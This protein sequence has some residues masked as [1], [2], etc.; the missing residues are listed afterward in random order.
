MYWWKV[1][2]ANVCLFFFLIGPIRI[3]FALF[4]TEWLVIIDIAIDIIFVINMVLQF[5]QSFLNKQ[6]KLEMEFHA[7]SKKYL[8]GFFLFD[9]LSLV[10]YYAAY[11]NLNVEIYLFFFFKMLRYVRLFDTGNIIMTYLNDF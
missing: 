6:Q 8:T 7:I 11:P 1:F 9:L 3:T 4:E 2:W 10:P 5:F